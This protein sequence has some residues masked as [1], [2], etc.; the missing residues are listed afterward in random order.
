LKSELDGRL[1]KGYTEDLLQRLKEH[2]SGKSKSTKGYK[3]WKI[4]YFEEFIT[5]HEALSREKYFKTGSGREYLKM[6]LAT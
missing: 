5:Q 3:P 2:N 6:K 4:V 1:Y